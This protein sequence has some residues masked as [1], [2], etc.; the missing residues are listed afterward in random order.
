[1][2]EL[3]LPILLL[4]YLFSAI[5]LVPFVAG[6]KGRNAFAWFVI[7]VLCSP[8]LALIALAAVPAKD[9][10]TRRADDTEGGG[11]GE[12]ESRVCPSCAE[13]VKRAA[14]V[15]RYCGRDLPKVSGGLP[16]WRR[17]LQE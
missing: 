11:A 9:R 15:C 4:L 1:M 13:T 17:P 3:V 14:V 2:G 6:E 8:A 10:R 5:F 12:D 7:A 16:P